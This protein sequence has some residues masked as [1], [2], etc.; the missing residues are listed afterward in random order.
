[1]VLNFDIVKK[2]E[3]ELFELDHEL[4]VTIPHDLKTAAD[5]GDLSENAEYD[6]AKERKRMVES[7]ISILQKRISE[8]KS[9]NVNQIPTDRVGIGSRVELEDLDTD[10]KVIYHFVFPEE[11]DPE[12]GKISLATPIG[13]AMVGRM[14][15]DEVVVTTPKIRREYEIV[16]LQTAHDLAK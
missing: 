9:V 7:R 5:H 16:K 6:A 13:K 12:N 14:V 3:E 4:K 10:E 11:A 8:I 1:M 15:G 2:L